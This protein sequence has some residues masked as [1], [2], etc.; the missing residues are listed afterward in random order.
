ME[1]HTAEDWWH[2]VNVHWEY[3]LNILAHQMDMDYVAYE[4]PGDD[5]S[6]ALE[7]TIF[8]EV[9][10]LRGEKDK[11]LAKYFH[12]AWCLAS[13]TYAWSVPGWGTLCDLCSED[14][15]LYEGATHDHSEASVQRGGEEPAF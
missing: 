9:V 2:A 14:W 13:E 10:H 1:I 15:V 3:L 5:S 7:R 12:A 8:Q 6:P 11:K 4:T